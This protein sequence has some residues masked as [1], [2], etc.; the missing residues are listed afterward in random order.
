[1]GADEL[2]EVLLG[3]AAVVEVHAL[4]AP[5]SRGALKREHRPGRLRGASSLP[6]AL[7]SLKAANSVVQPMDGIDPD[8]PPSGPECRARVPRRLHLDVPAEEQDLVLGIS[9]IARNPPL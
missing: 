9:E 2:L 3:S 7:H 1:M 6:F 5:A 4:R 8:I